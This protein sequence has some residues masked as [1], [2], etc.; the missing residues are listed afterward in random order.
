MNWLLLPHIGKKTVRGE[1]NFLLYRDIARYLGSRGDYVYL[2]VD[3]NFG[4]KDLPRMEGVRYIILPNPPRGLQYYHRMVYIHEKLIEECNRRRGLRMI[5]VA[6]TSR[7]MA[8][9]PLKMALSSVDVEWLPVLYLEPGA[10]D[11]VSRVRREDYSRCLV[12]SWTGADH[13]VLLTRRERDVIAEMLRKFSSPGDIDRFLQRVFINPVG[14]QTEL[15]DRY[16]ECSKNEKLT[17]FFAGRAKTVKQVDKIAALYDKVYKSGRDV[18]IVFATPGDLSS[19]SRKIGLSKLAENPNIELHENVGREAYLELASSAHVFVSWSSWEGFPVGFWEQMYLG[20]V[21]LFP[22][23]GWALGQLPEGYPFLFEDEE[24]AYALLTW[25]LDH[26]DEA[27]ERVAFMTD[28]IR[29]EYSKDAVWR[30]LRDLGLQ[31]TSGHQYK[32]TKSLHGLVEEAAAV[33]E[34][35]FTLEDLITYVT[36]QSTS[37]PSKTDTRASDFRYPGNY[38]FYRF[39]LD[40]GFRAEVSGN[41]LETIFYPQDPDHDTDPQRRPGIHPR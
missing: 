23:K 41:G 31:V 40:L 30:R 17:L 3:G 14:V 8:V 7:P 15:V 11:K 37:I 26:Y 12:Q 36:A 1:S 33:L 35:G 16:R 28:L 18:R 13:C 9:L 19:I 10:E 24:Q 38:D 2:V 6:L 25:V 34:S 21:G 4:S 27:R 22:T 20:L 32:L 29:E 5:D 39:L